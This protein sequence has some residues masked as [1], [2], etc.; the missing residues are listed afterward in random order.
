[1]CH[2]IVGIYA[3][4]QIVKLCKY[5]MWSDVQCV[6]TEGLPFNCILFYAATVAVLWGFYA[7]HL[8]SSVSRISISNSLEI[9]SELCRLDYDYYSSFRLQLIIMRIQ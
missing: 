9:A 6:R 5:R 3:N 8:F 7:E 1:M 4:V 2:K